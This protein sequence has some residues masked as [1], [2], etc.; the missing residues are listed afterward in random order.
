M[1]PATTL[2]QRQNEL[3]QRLGRVLSAREKFYLALADAFLHMRT[4][5]QMST[6]EDQEA[7]RAKNS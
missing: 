3:E 5:D 4:V 2:E 1:Y 6:L 7:A